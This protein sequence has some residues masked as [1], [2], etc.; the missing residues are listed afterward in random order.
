MMPSSF[1]KIAIEILDFSLSPLVKL[2][3]LIFLSNFWYNFF[4]SFLYFPF[5]SHCSLNYCE[6]NSCPSFLLLLAIAISFPLN[7]VLPLSLKK[8][9]T[10]A[11]DIVAITTQR[12]IEKRSH[13]SMNKFNTK[14]L[15]KELKVK[16]FAFAKLKEQ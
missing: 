11:K 13:E 5:Y 12:A 1:Y 10:I 9:T 15:S 2:S 3:L 16:T 4:A 7:F 8:A 6:S 14:K